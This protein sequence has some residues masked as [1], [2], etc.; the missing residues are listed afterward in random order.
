M[1]NLLSRT[2]SAAVLAAVTAGSAHA[3]SQAPAAATKGDQPALVTELV[4]T[5][6]KREQRLQ[7]VP[8]EVQT[9]PSNL[10][11]AAGVLDIKDMQILTPGLIVTSTTNE[12][13]TTARIRGIGTVGDNPGLESSVGMVIDGVYRP[14]DGVSFGDLGEVDRIEVLEG[15][16]GTTFGENTTAGVINVMTKAPSFTSSAEGEATFGDY[17]EKGGSLYVTGP[18]NDKLAGS[19]YIAERSRDGFYNVDTGAGPRTDTTDQDQN[20]WTIRGQLLWKPSD[21]F[22]MRLIA[23][24][25]KRDENCCV[26]VQSTVGP[27]APIIGALS[28]GGGISYPSADPSSRQAY[29]NNSTAQK[30]MD[31]GVS[32]QADWDIQDWNAKLTSISA[33]REWDTKNGADLDFTDADILSRT[34]DQN[35]EGFQTWTQELRLSGSTKHLDWLLGG[36]FENER[37]SDNVDYVLGDA[38][39][40]FISELL[41]QGNLRTWSTP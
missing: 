24:Y 29:A 19:L 34:P 17:G 40:P 41:S 2:A 8:I 27:T 22:S 13:V 35:T 11:K 39:T 28:G 5:A 36:Y 23:D 31:R 26:A 10:L 1:K 15:P 7:D 25:T 38:Y 20:Y 3:Q 12:T 33:F 18:I 9:L 37:L 32:L 4:V 14:R 6:Q 16:Q 21:I 30:I